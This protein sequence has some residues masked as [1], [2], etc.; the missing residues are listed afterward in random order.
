VPVTRQRRMAL[1]GG[2]QM[3]EISRDG[4]RPDFTNRSTVR[5]TSSSTRMGS[6]AD[7][8]A[9]CGAGR[10]HFLRSAFFMTGQRLTAR[11]RS[12]STGRLLVRPTAP[13]S[14][15]AAPAHGLALARL[16]V[17]GVGRARVFHGI[18]RRWVG[19][20]RSRSGCT[21]GPENRPLIRS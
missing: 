19:C 2:P 9:R 12:G 13:L 3:V 18:T 15:F 5:S 16:A 17:A 10:R 7:G 11:I 4:R 8:E 1:N 14:T 20:L 21:D 6:M